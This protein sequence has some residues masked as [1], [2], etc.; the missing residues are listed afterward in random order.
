MTG[1][2]A[3]AQG[4]SL[5]TPTPRPARCLPIVLRPFPRGLTMEP[6]NT[7]QNPSPPAPTVS[8][9]GSFSRERA[10][11]TGEGKRGPGL[12]R[13]RPALRES[14]ASRGLNAWEPRA[15][16]LPRHRPELPPEGSEVRGERKLAPGASE[17]EM[18][19]P[20]HLRGVRRRARRLLQVHLPEQQ[21]L[22]RAPGAG[23][24]CQATPGPGML[25]S[26]RC[27]SRAPSLVPPPR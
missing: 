9:S 20:P 16:F 22:S 1:A 2:R 19:T 26:G 14:G 8:G 24:P 13:G 5:R 10:T 21:V 7:Q 23:P 17:G 25:V 18:G 12:V 6:P 3:Q 11:R 27:G 4:A 15:P